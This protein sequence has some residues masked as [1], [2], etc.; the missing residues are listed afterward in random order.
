MVKFRVVR[1]WWAWVIGVFYLFFAGCQV[2]NELFRIL[3]FKY[4]KLKDCK[5]GIDPCWVI[6]WVFMI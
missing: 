3:G 4:A 6:R 5:G 2:F 1:V